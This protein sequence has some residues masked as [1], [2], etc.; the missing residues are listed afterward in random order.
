[1]T[2]PVF[3]HLDPPHPAMLDDAE[4]LKRCRV[5]FGRG[6]GPGGQH[7]NKVETAAR[8]V[9]GPTGLDAQAG[10]RRQQQQNRMVAVRRLRLR[11]ALRVRTSTLR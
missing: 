5:T 3:L 4:L 10:E 7:R 6:H 9:H 8:I 1:M 2:A 11:L